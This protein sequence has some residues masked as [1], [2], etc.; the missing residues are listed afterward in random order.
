MRRFDIDSYRSGVVRFYCDDGQYVEA[1]EALLL[2]RRI[3]DLEALL[4]RCE[5][6]LEVAQAAA[7]AEPDEYTLDEPG[8]CGDLRLKVATEAHR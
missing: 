6:W 5:P 1:E 4:R 2:L 8:N 7:E 3:A